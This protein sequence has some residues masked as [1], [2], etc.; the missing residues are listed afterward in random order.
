MRSSVP[1]KLLKIVDEIETKGS[2]PRTKLTVLK[3]W[4]EQPERLKAF[5]VWLATRAVS[6]KGK[7]GG[8]AEKLFREAR[9]LLAG[10]VSTR[11]SLDRRGAQELHG[12]LREFQNEY[13]NLA[14]GPVRII[15]HWNL[16]L[17]EE[18]LAIWLWHSDSPSEG[19]RLAAAYC[20]HYDPRQPYGLT[21]GS[22]SK[23]QEIVRFMFTVEALED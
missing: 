3:K 16:M 14:W 4:F 7:S 18:G 22:C 9:A 12:R 11:P 1:E 20:Q 5:A 17:V 10:S 8:A 21:R 23:I 6:R 13:R 15:H 2:V 19:Y